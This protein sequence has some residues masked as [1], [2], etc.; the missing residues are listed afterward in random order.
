[1]LSF[2]ST[3]F[4]VAEGEDAETN[5]GIFGK[6]LADW[7]SSRLKERGVPANEPFAEDWGW[8]VE[9]ANQ[10]HR[11][12]LA[13]ASEDN[14]KTA[15]R[16]YAFVDLGLLGQFRG[17]EAAVRAAN[18]LIAKVKEILSSGQVAT[19]LRTDEGA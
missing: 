5:P 11:T 2:E 4:A 3:A 14:E 17:K 7:L 6:A 10:K 8:C 12:G 18:D 13:C 9:L 19:N 16:V 1:M 15:W